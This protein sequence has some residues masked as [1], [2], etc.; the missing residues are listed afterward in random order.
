MIYSIQ[1]FF[2][3]SS[4]SFIADSNHIN[5]LWFKS[6]PTNQ[7]SVNWLNGQI[8]CW[9]WLVSAS[10]VDYSNWLWVFNA[11]CKSFSQPIKNF[12]GL[13]RA[14][15]NTGSNSPNWLVCKDNIVVPNIR[16]TWKSRN[17]WFKLIL[18]NLPSFVSFSFL[19]YLL[20]RYPP[21]FSR[22]S[23]W[24]WVHFLGPVLFLIQ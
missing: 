21:E 14:W 10:S 7:K 9:I 16:I 3:S 5:E 20:K 1:S 4:F 23:K 12:L 13:L 6:G 18:K 22:N 11:F 8:F 17:Y 19:K 24:L 15:W 2:K